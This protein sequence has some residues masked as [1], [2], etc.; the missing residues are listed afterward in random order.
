[1][2]EL[3]SQSKVKIFPRKNHWRAEQ[4]QVEFM[5]LEELLMEKKMSFNVVE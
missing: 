5:H 3:L 1:M 4:I 2:C